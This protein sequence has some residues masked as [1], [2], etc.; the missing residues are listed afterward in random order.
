M[1]LQIGL[2]VGRGDAEGHAVLL[3]EGVN[4]VTCFETLQPPHLTLVEGTRSVRLD[5]DRLKRT[6]RQILP[7]ALQRGSDVLREVD[8]DLHDP[9]RTA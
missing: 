3:Q 8:G 7:L 1:S 6:L 4:F 9:L 2:N 5:G